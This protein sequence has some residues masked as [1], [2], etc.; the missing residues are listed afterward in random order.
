MKKQKSMGSRLLVL[1]IAFILLVACGTTNS[2]NGTTS[3]PVSV[4]LSLNQTDQSTTQDVTLS[5]K[6]GNAELLQVTQPLQGDTT[7]MELLK[8]HAQI[9]ADDGFITSI[10]GHTQDEKAKKYWTYTVNGQMAQ[11]GAQDYTLK[12][13]DQVTFTLDKLSQ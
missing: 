9:E 11:V 2:G 3:S 1:F 12:A 13:G 8:A 7:V 4:S 10:D 5:V 6:D